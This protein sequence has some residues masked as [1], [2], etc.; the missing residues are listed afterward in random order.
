MNKIYFFILILIF[1]HNNIFSNESCY[2]RCQECQYPGNDE[3]HNC[4]ECAPGYYFIRDDNDFCRTKE[5][6]ES[7]YN[8]G[9]YRDLSANRL[10]D[11]FPRCKTCYD[12]NSPISEINQNCNQCND[13]LYK[14]DNDNPN[15]CYYPY[16]IE[17]YYYKKDGK[18]YECFE[19]CWTCSENGNNSENNCDS[20]KN[21]YYKLDH[22]ETGNC[23]QLDEIPDDYEIPLNEELNEIATQKI[24]VLL[25]F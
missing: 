13:N 4:L 18:F 16:E 21:E 6:A 1:R 12:T 5:E 11:C 14:K 15:N 17:N 23:V 2:E 25:K 3:N 19:R 24:T 10:K 9:F 20:C 7:I 22:K 8:C